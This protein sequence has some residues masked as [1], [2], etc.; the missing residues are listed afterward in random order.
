M[1]NAVWHVWLLWFQS[2]VCL[3]PH[4][5]NTP[6]DKEFSLIFYTC[7]KPRGVHRPAQDHTTT[8]GRTWT[9]IQVFSL[10]GK[11]RSCYRLA[12]TGGCCLSGVSV[13]GAETVMLWLLLLHHLP[14]PCRRGLYKALQNNSPGNRWGEGWILS[15]RPSH[16]GPLSSWAA[17]WSLPPVCHYLPRCVAVREIPWKLT[18]VKFSHLLG[19][20]ASS[21]SLVYC[22]T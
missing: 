11:H 8:H 3:W 4:F 22:S 1:W 7:V 9:R 21:P 13:H 18:C 12:C 16:A 6:V 10:P 5:Q 19:T 14:S 2:G 17:L 20:S 15:S